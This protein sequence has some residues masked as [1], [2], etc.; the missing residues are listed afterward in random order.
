MATPGKRRKKYMYA[1]EPYLIPVSTLRHQAACAARRTEVDTSSTESLDGEDRAT[2][3]SSVDS[4]IGDASTECESSESASENLV[5]YRENSS[6]AEVRDGCDSQEPGW[7]SFGDVFTPEPADNDE[8]APG[9][10]EEDNDEMGPGS[11]EDFFSLCV[12]EFGTSTLPHSP[13]TK[14]GAIAMIMSYAVSERSTWTGLG[15]LLSLVNTLFGC[16]VLP[17]TTY[18]FRK[19]WAKKTTEIVKYHY[20]CPACGT[21]LDTDCTLAR[22]NACQF[23]ETTTKLRRDGSYFL[24]LDFHEQLKQLIAKPK[25]ELHCS[26]S[27]VASSHSDVI[28]DITTAEAYKRLRQEV[29]F[30]PSDLTLT[31]NTDGS[32]IFKSSKT[33]V[34]PV[35]F[36][37]NE[38]P[39]SLRLHHPTL[40]GL[41]FGKC[42]PDMS[43]F[44]TK[45]VDE[46]NNMTPVEW[47]HGDQRHVSKAF[48]LCCSVDA[49]ARAAVQNM[50]LFN[51]F[52]GC[53][54]CLIKGEHEEGC[55]RYVSDEAPAP[56]TSE[57]VARDME[58]ALRLGSPVNGIKGP[59][60]LMNLQ[61][62][63]LVA[64]VSVEYMHCVL[65]G[66]VRQI[67][68]LFFS[69]TSS[70]QAYYIDTRQSVVKVDKRLRG[71]KP[72][73]CITRLPRS[74]EERGFWK[75]SEWKQWLLFY[76]LPC[77][78]D[79]LPQLYW[80]HLCKLSEAVHI[81]LRDSLTL[82]DIKRAELSFTVLANS[83]FLRKRNFG[84][85]KRTDI[86]PVRH[87]RPASRLH[88]D[89]AEPSSLLLAEDI[90]RSNV[91]HENVSRVD[92]TTMLSCGRPA[93]VSTSE[94]V[95]LQEHCGASV[96]MATEYQRSRPGRPPKR[97]GLMLALANS[98]VQ[99]GSVAA[100]AQ[101]FQAAKK[102]RTDGDLS[103]VFANGEVYDE[104]VDKT[105]LLL[106]CL[107]QQMTDSAG[108]AQTQAAQTPLANG[109]PE[110]AGR[111][112]VAAMSPPERRPTPV[113]THRR[114]G[115]LS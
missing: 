5:D 1:D 57:L 52:F 3:P 89:V 88:E 33:S 71:I 104:S 8:M 107:R 73:H 35:Q 60:A 86:H 51:G 43:A 63:D 62:F 94:R 11:I 85:I 13:T 22:C 16:T 64:G 70:R 46:V 31:F 7:R 79:I 48:I 27:E 30:G 111:N 39:P 38:L 82:H 59:S 80:K 20:L 53:P 47:M 19:L 15:K 50:V 83:V 25:T 114:F 58:L 26:L 84:P 6:D 37:V 42:H 77:L 105:T 92:H 2:E 87:A 75:A 69:S 100:A 74:I 56:R 34:W 91:K 93:T 23:E 76:A 36:I 66:V 96:D 28:T 90:A 115:S 81:L 72:P 113:S 55:V 106:N 41:W 12:E 78:M 65:Q 49:P 21:V 32:P 67:T 17:A 45:F 112:D 61:G 110:S 68:E 44:M 101:S 29:A 4:D 10:F 97:S 108:R 14:A 18:K 40:A 9:A 95:A 98:N 103:A 99:S 102:L 54:W 24:M 109:R